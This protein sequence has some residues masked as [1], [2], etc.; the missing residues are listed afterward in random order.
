[1]AR[2]KA[3]RRKTRRTKYKNTMQLP[4][5]QVGSTTARDIKAVLWIVLGIVLFLGLTGYAGSVGTMFVTG[6]AKVF[7]YGMWFV[8]LICFILGGIYFLL[9]AFI[10]TYTR[11]FGIFLLFVSLLGLLHLNISLDQ[12]LAYAQAGNGGGIIGFTVSFIFQTFLGRPATGVILFGIFL[13]GIMV[14]FDLNMRKIASIIQWFIDSPESSPV[15]VAIREPKT[16]SEPEPFKNQ[17]EKKL[18]DTKTLKDTSKTVASVKKE[19]EV[20]DFKPFLDSTEDYVVPD[21]ALLNEPKVT[22]EQNESFI[23]ENKK[24]IVKTLYD[25]NILKTDLEQWLKESKIGDISNLSDDKKEIIKNN[26]IHQKISQ[27]E[28]NVGPTVTQFAFEPPAGVKLARITAL[29]NDLALALA[30]ESLRIEAPIPG[31]SR[32]GI[33]VPNETRADVFLKDMLLS[34]EF[35]S[36]KGSL[37]IPIGKDVSGAPVVADLAEMP[38]LLIAGATGAGKSVGIN[39]IILS[40][41]FTKSPDDLKLILVDPKRVELTNYNKIPHLLTPV[42]TDSEKTVTALRWAVSEMNR[43]YKVLEDGKVKNLVGYNQKYPER[44]LPYIV[45]VVDELADLMMVAAKEVEASICRIAQLARAVGIHLVV[46]TQRPSVDVITG[47]IK[48][49]I[50]SRVAYTVSAGID[51]RTILDTV[52]AERLLGKGDMLYLDRRY[53]KPTRLQGVFVSNK[54]IQRVISEIRLTAST[55]EYQ[56]EIVEEQREIPEGVPGAG[57]MGV[58]KGDDMEDSLEKEAVDVIIE[59]KKA[60]ASLLQRRLRVGYARAARILDILEEKG[61]IGPSRGAKPREIY[62]QENPYG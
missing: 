23:E 61:Y 49:N 58:L 13:V 50:P 41:L 56:M 39:S 5:L 11:V 9:P 53:P 57:T 40:F 35:R 37:K 7:G 54:E 2:K 28:H 45:I 3:K 52:G 42:I 32:V 59:T 38:H 15:D 33:E 17:K 10:P 1:M 18:F 6:A 24:K 36:L 20:I 30:A 60:S 43:R 27:M 12:S 16:N 62:L 25:F 8:P 19:P 22:A 46:A 31:Q 21:I 4:E 34:K 51:S 47:L 55:P 48:A 26:Y 44:K 29:H 14:T